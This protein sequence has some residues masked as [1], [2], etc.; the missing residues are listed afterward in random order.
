MIDEVTQRWILNESDRQ[1]V[2]AGCYLSEQ[3]GLDVI[4][5]VEGFC[6][7]SKGRWAG[8][9][10]ELFDWQK[11]MLMRLFGW[12]KPDGRRRFR[13]CHLEI[14]KKSGKSTLTSALALYMLLADGEA[15]PEVY[16]NAVD[17]DQASIIFDECVRM[18]EF[19]PTLKRR[20]Q[21]IASRKV[22]LAGHGR[23]VAN[24]A[25]SAK[26][27]GLSPSGCI[28]DEVHRQPNRFLWDVFEYAGVAREQPLTISL[29][30]AGETEGELWHELREYAEKTEAGIT[31]D[32]TFLGIIY[33]ADPEA[34]IDDPETW[35]AANPSLGLTIGIDDFRRDL[36]EA[37]QV[38]AK[39]GLFKRLRLNIIAAGEDRYID[40]ELWN[41]RD[42][43]PDVEAGADCY[44]GLDLSSRDDLSALVMLTGD[45]ASGFRL[46]ARFWLPRDEIERLERTHQMPYRTWA[47]EGLIRLTPGNAV[48]YDFIE[49]E[50][51]EI[52]TTFNVVKL[53]LDP[54]NAKRLGQSLLNTH[55]LPVVEVRQGYATLTDPT[56]RFHELVRSGKI[57]H[58]GHPIM[59]WHASNC[60]IMMDPAGNWKLDKRKRNRKIDGIAAAICALAVAIEHPEE[61]SCVYDT[62]GQLAL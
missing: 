60:V 28:F 44:L 52:S 18:V 34:D 7:Q 37:K 12:R 42:D 35:K 38:P 19:S 23:L 46:E 36:E 29:T 13:K 21:I 31:G 50:I 58:G 24:S 53:G 27:D 57:H 8:K 26:Q 56:K 33:R 9:A 32:I 41:A 54:W 17:R 14:A 20:V 55:G 15:A 11:S 2:A 48:D 3:H 30:T 25:E 49:Q 16:L 45:F 10:L 5:F 61:A 22:I 62:P 39:L 59:R 6:R 47:E 40:I 1:A 43:W 4:N 51:I